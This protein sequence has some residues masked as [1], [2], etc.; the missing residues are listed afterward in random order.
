MSEPANNKVH[1]RSY[2]VACMTCRRAKTKCVNTGIQAHRC[3]RCSRLGKDC[4]YESIRRVLGRKTDAGKALRRDHNLPFN[5]SSAS[6]QM[7]ILGH[8]LTNAASETADR[9]LDET[10]YSGP[11]SL[12]SR[13][14]FAAGADVPSFLPPSFI[15]RS[16]D[17][18][19][20]SLDSA[21]DS[22]STNV[23]ATSQGDNS[24][25]AG[26]TIELIWEREDPVSLKLL[27]RPA[28]QYLYDGYFKHFNDLVGLLDPQLYT[29][30]YTRQK[31]SLLFGMILRIS[32]KVFQP[33]SYTKIRSHTERLLSQALVSCDSAIET[34]WAII[35]LYHWKD[36]NDTRGYSLIGF[37]LRLA[38]S[39][40]W[41][42]LRNNIPDE[43]GSHHITKTEV[44]VR[45][46]RD[47]ARIWLALENL[48]RTREFSHSIEELQGFQEELHT[49]NMEMV[50]WAESWEQCFTESQLAPNPQRFHSAVILIH[51]D[52]IR[53]YFNSVL[54]HRMLTIEDR[55]TRNI[56]VYTTLEVCY[57]SALVIL[58]QITQIGKTGALY[59]F[60][61]AAHLMVSYAAMVLP[62]LLKL[63][64]QLPVVSMH[65][66]LEALHNATAA[67]S[68]A[69]GLLA[70]AKPPTTS[71]SDSSLEAQARLLES[72]LAKL[73]SEVGFNID[74]E[75]RTNIQSS[76]TSSTSIE[77]QPAG[78][79]TTSVYDNDI[80][81]VQGELHMQD[82]IELTP[83]I[84]NEPDFIFDYDFMNSRFI[85][86]GLLS[87]DEPGIFLQPH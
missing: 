25:D 69:A 27:N 49:L 78:K 70:V 51:R 1:R 36:V 40:R 66:A 75:S 39:A 35:C 6:Y 61:D 54:L 87:W 67:Y 62:K 13:T 46:R 12:D 15:T 26:K 45:Q 71:P 16:E 82:G 50:A 64:L 48:D 29:F 41:N 5:S 2:G 65:E 33:V 31:S 52:Y 10:F 28:A 24:L 32:S 80:R 55:A 43:E 73:R 20:L 84:R 77:E 86:A 4:V 59:Y 8:Q 22:T 30:S 44:E 9:W 53:L 11:P 81:L 37:A 38:A 79:V 57:S 18:R 47:E 34:V 17:A 3:D 68:N 23:E 60:W 21:L 14:S 74:K 7:G 72:I 42:K 56:D 58:R 85:D 83:E 63:G 19:G 76:T